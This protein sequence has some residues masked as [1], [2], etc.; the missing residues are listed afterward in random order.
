[1]NNMACLTTTSAGPEGGRHD[2]ETSDRK[3]KYSCT[4]TRVFTLLDLPEDVVL[5]L[6]GYLCDIEDYMNVSS[7][8]RALRNLMSTVSPHTILRL[9]AN[10]RSSLCKPNP[11]VVVCAVAKQIGAW[12]RAADANEAELV[13]GMPRGINHLLDLALRTREIGLTMARIRELHALRSTIIEPTTQ[14]IREFVTGQEYDFHWLGRRKIIFD[15]SLTFFLLATYGEIFGPDFDL[16]AKRRLAVYTRLEFVKY[17]IPQWIISQIQSEWYSN[18]TPDVE[19]YGPRCE[20]VFHP[21]GPYRSDEGGG[22]GNRFD[23]MAAMLCLL[24]SREWRSQWI[25]AMAEPG[26]LALPAVEYDSAAATDDIVLNREQVALENILQWQ[27]LEGLSIIWRGAAKGW[28]KKIEDWRKDIA[29]LERSPQ[30]LIAGH[31]TPKNYP[32]LQRDLQICF[33][34]RMQ[35][36][37]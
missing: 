10:S 18:G 19:S 25:E 37:N 9:A 8:C 21:E 22:G 5:M 33:H 36:S 7:T 12:A 23:H 27:G 35:R 1:M 6:P 4:T 16:S 28:K 26:R 34:A 15:A 17:C 32:N 11:H 30:V 3:P 14:L 20:I 13:A 2:E 24:Q 31:T 29:F